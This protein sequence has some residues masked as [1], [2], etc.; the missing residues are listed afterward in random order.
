[1]VRAKNR[2]A[3]QLNMRKKNKNKENKK[4]ICKSKHYLLRHLPEGTTNL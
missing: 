1:M 3:D 4:T 2:S